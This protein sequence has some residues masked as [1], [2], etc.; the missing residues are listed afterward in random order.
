M[1]KSRRE[2]FVNVAANDSDAMWTRVFKYHIV[3][4]LADSE[5]QCKG[6]EK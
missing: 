1:K 5:L 4:L 6:V 2:H 3:Y